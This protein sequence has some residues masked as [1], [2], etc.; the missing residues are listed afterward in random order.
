MATCYSRRL[1]YVDQLHGNAHY[2]LPAFGTVRYEQE[3]G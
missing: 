2:K 3:L 1:V